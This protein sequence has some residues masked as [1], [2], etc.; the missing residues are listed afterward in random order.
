[1]SRIDVQPTGEFAF[2]RLPPEVSRKR[3]FG[4]VRITEKR[5]NMTR[6]ADC[7]RVLVESAVDA[8]ANPPMHVG[9]KTESALPLVFVDTDLQ[10]HVAFLDKIKQTQPA[11]QVVARH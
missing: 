5:D 2:R 11:A 6:Q 4:S 3:T 8:L 10:A 9:T 7:A 1:M